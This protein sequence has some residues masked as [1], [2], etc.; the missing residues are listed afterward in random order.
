MPAFQ[1]GKLSSGL[2]H[3]GFN[4]PSDSLENQLNDIALYLMWQSLPH[5]SLFCCGQSLA[6]LLTIIGN[7]G[8]SR[9]IMS[10]RMAKRL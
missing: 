3:I 2:S 4:S 1:Q 9:T 5:G 8:W 6:N 10:G 7:D